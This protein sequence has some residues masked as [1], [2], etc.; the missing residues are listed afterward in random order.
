MCVITHVQTALNDTAVE[1]AENIWRHTKLLQPPLGLGLCGG[2]HWGKAGH[3][4]CFAL[5]N[6]RC[7]VRSPLFPHVHHHL[8]CLVHVE[9]EVVVLTMTSHWPPPSCSP[10]PIT[11]LFVTNAGRYLLPILTDWVLPV[12]RCRIQ[13]QGLG[14]RP[15]HNVKPLWMLHLRSP[16]KV[17]E[18]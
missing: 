7:P 12:R 4:L 8:L 6:E 5:P 2:P 11:A 10:H 17:R 16:P 14:C 1:V 15:T 13:S 9:G 3:P 18:W